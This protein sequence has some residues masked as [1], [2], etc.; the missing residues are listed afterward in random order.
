[1]MYLS[2][3]GLF[4]YLDPQGFQ[5]SVHAFAGFCLIVIFPVP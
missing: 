2:D 1:M 5:L 3:I 4:A